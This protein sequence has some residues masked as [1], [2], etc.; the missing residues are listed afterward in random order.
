MEQ[1]QS[2]KDLIVDIDEKKVYLPEFQRD[3]VWEIS[4]TYDLFDSL[5]K[6]IFIGAIIFGIPSF[7]IAIR[8][9]DNRKKIAKGRRRPS[10]VVKTITKKEIEDINKVGGNF[11]LILDGQ[12]R[13]TSIY[14]ALKGT[15]EVWFI[16]KNEDEIEAGSFENAKL[17][18]LLEEISGEQDPERLSIRLSDVWDIEQ[19]DYDEDEIRDKFF[20][21]TAY[22]KMYS[23]DEEFDRKAEFKK[24]RNLRKKIADLFKSEKLLS[25]Y[26]L[27]MNLEKFVVFFER[28]NTRGVQ[29]NFIDIL[30]AKLY[31]GN[32]NLKEKIKEFEIQNPNIYLI[33]EIIV[34]SIA[35]IKSSPK[36]I[37]RN[38][39]LTSL[40]ADDFK[41]WWD[42]AC[43]LYKV[44]LDFL[45]QNN[46]IISQEWMPYDNMIIP[47]MNFLQEVG[48][49]FHRMNL[50]QKKF[51]EYWY[52][53]SIFSLRYSGSSNERIIEDSNILIQIAREKKINSSSYFNR[54][55]KI[56]TLSTD[57][58]YSFDKKANAVYKG[59]LNLINYEKSGLINWNNDA[60]LSLNS[61]LEDHHIYPKNYLNQ[62]LTTENEKDLI[63]CVANR[64]LM[65]KIQ[66][67]KI[68]DQAPSKY[69]NEIKDLNKNIEKSLD[70]H[71]ITTDLLNGEYDNEF[72]FFIELRANSI[73]EI[74]KKRLIDTR[75]LIKDEFYEEIKYDEAV[76]I[77]VYSTYKGKKAEATFNPATA[78][79]FFKGKL[80]AS[81]SAA[82]IAVKIENGASDTAT[83]NGWTFWKFTD[84]NGIEKR[85]NDL[86][87]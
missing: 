59:I 3:F 81:P 49:D 64:T 24:F 40:N 58:I 69:L 42:S 14:R 73:F 80:Y 78:K 9:I 62:L 63:D 71:L 12:Q 86:R 13:T 68:S 54:L 38:Y 26:L 34:R 39:I 55:S 51:I 74:I 29:L 5:I 53:N 84:E 4:K 45:Y 31:T 60:K 21:T 18:E 75:D 37:D 19:N 36:E 25:Y 41:R 77:N 72:S 70:N 52:W 85:I 17:E 61:S 46:F 30:A 76:N 1:T 28:S 83:E 47:L 23:S 43:K 67:I 2:I 56:Q 16:S 33:P 57:D 82:A 66:N 11:R 65:P 79:V 8:E 22:Y 87:K 48:G 35:F 27:D 6:D 32:F 10:L 44:T 50:N 15:D 20:Y 7:D